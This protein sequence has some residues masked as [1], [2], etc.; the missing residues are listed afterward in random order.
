MDKYLYHDYCY[1]TQ[2]VI[3]SLMSQS[4]M[5]HVGVVL[6]A[7]HSGSGNFAVLF[8]DYQT[9]TQQTYTLTLPA[10]D[11]LG[12]DNSYTG[13]TVEDSQELAWAIV[14][15]L[16]VAFSFRSLKRSV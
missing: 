3:D 8:Q 15:V 16:V 12:F 11:R 2:G 5:P 13:L 6:N 1:T 7:T 9:S 4:F 14:L 10:C